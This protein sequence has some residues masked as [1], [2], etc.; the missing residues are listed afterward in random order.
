MESKNLSLYSSK[1]QYALAFSEQDSEDKTVQR[2]KILETFDRN[3]EGNKNLQSCLRKVR[4]AYDL[5]GRRVKI[6]AIDNDCS[7]ETLR[8]L[9]LL[10]KY[11]VK[12]SEFDQIKAVTGSLLDKKITFDDNYLK[13]QILKDLPLK[14][15]HSKTLGARLGALALLSQP[16]RVANLDDFCSLQRAYS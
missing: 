11:D 3:P 15:F 12:P 4:D 10:P 8:K 13:H 14:F 1:R 6:N 16:G 5:G 7:S 9:G 2:I